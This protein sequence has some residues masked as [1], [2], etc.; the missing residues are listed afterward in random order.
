MAKYS[1]QKRQRR[2]RITGR[3]S[4]MAKTHFGVRLVCPS[5]GYE[6]ISFAQEKYIKCPKCGAYLINPVYEIAENLVS[7]KLK[8]KKEEKEALELILSGKLIPVSLLVRKLG[9]GIRE[10][11]KY[12]ERK[13]KIKIIRIGKKMYIPVS[14]FTK[15]L[16]LSTPAGEHLREIVKEKTILPLEIP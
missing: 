9:R 5:C 4:S 12:Y 11:L 8:L 10:S 6:W 16:K 14:E 13:G 2:K 1:R 3:N 15:L 7:D